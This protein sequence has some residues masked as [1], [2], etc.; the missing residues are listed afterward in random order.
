VKGD[1]L[2]FRH[3]SPDHEWVQ[4]F[5]HPE[6]INDPAGFIRDGYVM[7]NQEWLAKLKTEWAAGK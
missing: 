4:C 3:C 7:V 2:G 5:P 1:R 6:M